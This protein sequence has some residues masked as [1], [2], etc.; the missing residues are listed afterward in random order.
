MNK[1]RIDKI[2][3]AAAVQ[4]FCRLGYFNPH[5]AFDDKI[6][7]WDGYL[8][9]LKYEDTRKAEDIDFVVQ[10]QIKS[11]ERDEIDNIQETSQKLS[12]SDLKHYKEIGGTLLIKALVNKTNAKLF[13]AYLG[14]LE[15]NRLLEECFEGQEEKV[16]KLKAAAT[17]APE[18]VPELRSIH[19][20]GKH[21]LLAA[22]TLINRTD[23]TLNTLVGPIPKEVNPL[24][25]M[26]SHPTDILVTL[27]EHKEPFYLSEGP[28][29]IFN[30]QDVEQPVSIGGKVLFDSFQIGTFPQ[31]CY[32]RIGEFLKFNYVNENTKLTNYT[33]K[34]CAPSLG[35]YIRELQFVYLLNKY[36]SFYLGN[37]EIKA[38]NFDLDEDS[39]KHIRK[40]LKFWSN[41]AS[42]FVKMK[43]EE[44]KFNVCN[45]SK[46]E[47]NKL[48]ELIDYIVFGKEI[49]I[50]IPNIPFLIYNLGGY[51]YA[52]GIKKSDLG[53]NLTDINN[54]LTIIV[55]DKEHGDQIYPVYAYLSLNH[56]FPEN[57][58]YNSII[59]CY[60]R[61][62]GSYDLLNIANNNILSY[63]A[64]FDSFGYT[65]ILEK[66]LELNKWLISNCSDEEDLKIFTLNRLQILKR[67]EKSFSDEDIDFLIS[68]SCSNPQFS[69]AANV[70]LD[71][72]IRATKSW[73]KLSTEDKSLIKELPIYTLYKKL[74]KPNNEQTENAE[75]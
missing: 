15:L 3:V 37:F 64:Y 7:V 62:K 56:I 51:C 70:L 14:K 63:I 41:V 38:S 24:I 45:L 75:S 25:W 20:Q 12:I 43:W 2:G 18:I 71:D 74:N 17:T 53:Y 33:I 9:V 13:F 44:P 5:F 61:C 67:L 26:A 36:K 42:I 40:C 31:G 23:Y 69:F 50:E 47:L 55:K 46:E 32:Y 54:C 65:Y 57:L 34:P 11:S 68:I 73:E 58:K 10:V 22:E 19:L 1:D 52:L 66:A 27:P 49:N 21:N 35:K 59:D 72:N 29:F 39:K 60:N 16:I 28:S 8:E 6:A 30:E 48:Q 4:Y